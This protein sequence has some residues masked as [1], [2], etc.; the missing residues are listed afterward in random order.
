MVGKCDYIVGSGKKL[1][2]HCLLM[3]DTHHERYKSCDY[4]SH[5]YQPHLAGSSAV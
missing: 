1:S 4:V 3:L 5:T 2:S